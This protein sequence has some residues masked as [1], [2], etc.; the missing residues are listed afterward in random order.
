MWRRFLPTAGSYALENY[1]A[2]TSGI[3]APYLT[4]NN[5]DPR[6]SAWVYFSGPDFWTPHSLPEAV[7]G[8][9]LGVPKGL[10][11]APTGL[12]GAE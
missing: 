10:P 5:R 1:S 12:S 6:G 9:F 7:E 2:P 3:V 11:G 4:R 8:S